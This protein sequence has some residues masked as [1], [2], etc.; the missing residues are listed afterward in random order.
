[1]T[2]DIGI[3]DNDLLGRDL[4]TEEE[5]LINYARNC[6]K[7]ANTLNYAR[8]NYIEDLV[9]VPLLDLNSETL[10][11]DLVVKNGLCLKNASCHVQATS[12]W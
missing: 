6:L 8:I 11:D 7:L 3:E 5:K 9:S 10:I 4:L 12:L 2:G 1:M